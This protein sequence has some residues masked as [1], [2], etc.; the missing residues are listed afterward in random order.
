MRGAAAPVAM[1]ALVAMPALLA[2][3]SA[4]AAQTAAQ[5][6]PSRPVTMMVPFAAGGPV[7]VLGRILAQYLSEVIGKQRRH[8]RI[9][10][11]RAGR[12]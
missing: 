11:G 12:T 3:T 10:A 5:D 7:D 9:A 8:E 6:W 4:G 2:L 1:L